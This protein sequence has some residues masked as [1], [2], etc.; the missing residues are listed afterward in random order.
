MK[1][2]AELNCGRNREY[3]LFR[4]IGS[5]ALL[6]TLTLL[7]GAGC[8]T[9]SPTAQIRPWPLPPPPGYATLF[10]YSAAKGPDSGPKVYID[11]VRVFKLRW[12]TYTWVYVLAG[13]HDIST[14][15]GWG[16]GGLNSTGPVQF[17]DGKSYNLKLAG[18]I[19]SQNE[20][21]TETDKVYASFRPVSDDLARVETA[22]CDYQK[23]R[24]SE[25]NTIG[26]RLPIPSSDKIPGQTASTF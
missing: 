7:L 11:H 10:M 3:G 4:I 16:L 12:N 15:W 22:A 18:Y 2:I 25:I 6:L 21:L 5:L 14:K 17:A 20:G 13:E 9:P 23:P 1:N 19:N 8:A 26:K 24:M